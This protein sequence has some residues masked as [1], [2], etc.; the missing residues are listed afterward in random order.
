[1]SRPGSMTGHPIGGDQPRSRAIVSVVAAVES[2]RHPRRAVRDHRARR[3]HRPIDTMRDEELVDYLDR[4]G[5]M[6]RLQRALEEDDTSAGAPA[7]ATRVS[8]REG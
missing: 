6:S 7:A 5:V 2:I 1:M 3:T 4:T 8:R